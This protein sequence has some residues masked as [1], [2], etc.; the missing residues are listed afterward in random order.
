[1][2]PKT[3]LRVRKAV[4]TGLCRLIQGEASFAQNYGDQ[5]RTLQGL[6]TA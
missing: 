4:L 6:G 2:P 1:M 5:T 3:D